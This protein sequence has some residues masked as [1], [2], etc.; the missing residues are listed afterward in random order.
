VEEVE[1]AKEAEEVKEA[2]EEILRIRLSAGGFSIPLFPSL[3][4]LPSPGARSQ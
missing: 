1:D 3:P 2:M 4:Q